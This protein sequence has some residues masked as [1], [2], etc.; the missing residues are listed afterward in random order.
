LAPIAA[1]LDF[2]PVS[3]LADDDDL[4]VT[5]AEFDLTK[6]PASSVNFPGDYRRSAPSRIAVHSRDTV[7]STKPIPISSTAVTLENQVTPGAEMNESPPVRQQVRLTEE[8]HATEA[9]Q[10][11]RGQRPAVLTK[12]RAA[13]IIVKII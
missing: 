11:R 5:I 3:P 8:D 9:E 2:E 13:T 12:H 4:G 1:V 6:R 7:P 10:S